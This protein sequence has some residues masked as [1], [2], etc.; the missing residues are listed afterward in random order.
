MESGERPRISFVLRIWSEG[1]LEPEPRPGAAGVWRGQIVEV[2]SGAR[3][4]VQSVDEI[5]DFIVPY[6][7]AMGVAPGGLRRCRGWLDELVARLRAY[8]PAR[9]NRPARR[10]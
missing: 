9:L 1:V 3:R 6:L 2:T 7:E 4:T 8:R 10:G 5:W